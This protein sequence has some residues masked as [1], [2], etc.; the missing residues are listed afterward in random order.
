MCHICRLT[1]PHTVQLRTLIL[2]FC[3]QA[4]CIDYFII[5]AAHVASVRIVF[6]WFHERR[7][8]VQEILLCFLHRVSKLHLHFG[9]N[10]IFIN[11]WWWILGSSYADSFDALRCFQCR[12]AVRLQNWS[13]FVTSS[14]PWASRFAT[15]YMTDELLCS[16]SFLMLF[17]RSKVHLNYVDKKRVHQTW[18]YNLISAY[19]NS[20]DALLCSQCWT[21]DR[22]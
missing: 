13:A 19:A 21:A 20:F 17:M 15:G 18:C 22:L 5:A 7:R 4:I 16:T 10:N 14:Q 11:I 6:R 1:T 9:S 2:A 8:T 3:A 12:V